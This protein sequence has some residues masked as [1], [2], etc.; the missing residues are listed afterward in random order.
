V[1]VALRSCDFFNLAGEPDEA[2]VGRL[3]QFALR[4]ETLFARLACDSCHCSMWPLWL[5]ACA[6][7]G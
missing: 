3:F 6:T 2:W 1:G 5:P 7:A 4:S